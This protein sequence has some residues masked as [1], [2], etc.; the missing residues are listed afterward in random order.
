M[1]SKI[2]KFY[3]KINNNKDIIIFGLSY[4]VYS[5]KTIKLLKKY[6]ISFKYYLVD[7]YFKLFFN[8]LLDLAK[9]YPNL[10]IDITHKTV[11]IIFYKRKFIGGFDELK[12]MINLLI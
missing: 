10:N 7:N 6:N 4:C 2:N 9:L 1:D 11:P 8:I 12:K 3:K 5:N